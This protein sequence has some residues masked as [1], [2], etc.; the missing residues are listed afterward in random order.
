MRKIK[1]VTWSN[2]T[3]VVVV[4]LPNSVPF[5]SRFLS[6]CNHATAVLR[7]R[8]RNFTSDVLE[9]KG[10]ASLCANKTLQKHPSIHFKKYK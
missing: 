5:P 9:H 4:F 1:I 6:F 3:A 8:I 7:N 2:G 10:Q